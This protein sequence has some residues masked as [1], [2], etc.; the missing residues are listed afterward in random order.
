MRIFSAAVW[1]LC[2]GLLGVG[3]ASA[4]E[5]KMPAPAWAVDAAK[6]PT[7]ADVGDA[8]AVVLLDEYVI[9]VDAEHR[10]VERERTVVR[11][12][13]PQGREYAHCSISYDVD[14]KLNF[15]HA[16]TIAADG[17][18]FQA[19]D[20]DF[21][22]HGNYA[23]ATLQFTE[24]TRV[25]KPQANDPGAVVACETEQ[26]LRSYMSFENWQMQGSIPVVQAAL[27]L[28]LPP[29]EHFATSWR[30]HEPVKPAELGP[31]HL[32]W[33]IWN[34]PRLDLEN[35]HATPSWSALAA[36][37]SVFWGDLAVQ[38]AER[39][40]QA[41][42][43]WGAKLEEHRTDP[44]PELAA[45]A[46]ELVAGA[47]D[48]YTKL[49]RITDYIQK[50]VRYFVVIRGIG[51]WQA[52]PAGQIFRNHYGDCKDKTTLLIAMLKSVGVDAYYF[53][54]DSRRGVIDP[55]AP[56]LAG[57]HMITAIALPAGDK[58]ARLAA[59]VTTKSGKTLLIFDPTDE[60]T[61]VGLTRAA[62]QGAWGN[63]FDGADSQALLMPV[64]AP[65]TAGVERAGS[66]TLALNGDLSGTL[67]ETYRGDVAGNERSFLKEN[68]PKEIRRRLETSL[69]HSMAGLSLKSYAFQQM[70]AL[71]KPLGLNL[72][73]SLSSYASPAGP[74]LL[75]KPRVLGSDAHL[76]PEVMA[77]KPRQFPI[78]LG[79]PGRWH[80]RYEIALP[81]GYKVDEVPDPVSLDA[82]FASYRTSVAASE[83]KLVYEREYVVRAVEIPAEKAGD[84][85]RFE[86][87]I[88]TDEASAVV[89]KK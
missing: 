86:A 65:E 87:A 81:E 75:L 52:H 24:Q 2:M 85:R 36:R 25:V 28:A 74:L 69:G 54:V 33:E 15:F 18:Q 42:G 57:N 35:Q 3:A 43:A 51:G 60:E 56:S 19:L 10:A 14:E 61:P 59:R 5:K 84:F 23:D 89:L 66:F 31:N 55:K 16:W 1:V 44:T 72:E 30:G 82:G 76:V 70:E 63:L 13:K 45:K 64:L 21:T 37:M 73:F 6:T 27:E 41:I 67:H 79:Q 78:E 47:P 4:K 50:N 22:D 29:G 68:E 88:L 39:Q 8:P 62:L 20:E 17:R 7:P 77:G 34:M 83:G 40:W 26:Q 58:D 71:D 49:S 11:I 9:T 48:L 12:L 80:D 32:R 46:Q 53:H 38:G